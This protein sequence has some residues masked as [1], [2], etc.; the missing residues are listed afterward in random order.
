MAAA[1]NILMLVV[2]SSVRLRLRLRL[3]VRVRFNPNPDQV[4]DSLDGRLLDEGSAVYGEVAL[5][6]L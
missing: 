6:R 5:P 2:D 3:R 4:V 1:P